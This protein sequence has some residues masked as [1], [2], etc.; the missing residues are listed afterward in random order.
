M[1]KIAF[2]SNAKS[3][4]FAPPPPLEEKK[5]EER[6]R[7]STAVLSITARAKKREAAKTDKMDVVR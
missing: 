6:E 4:M 3:S 2:K 1:P 7:V 5:R